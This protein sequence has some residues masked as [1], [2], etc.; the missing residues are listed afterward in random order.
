[1]SFSAL[2]E[3]QSRQVLKDFFFFFKLHMGVLPVKTWMEDKG[4][5]AAWGVNCFLCI[6]AE[7]VEHVFLDCW[8]GFSFGMCYN[9]H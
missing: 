2:R 5:F 1:M 6:K 9:E 8:D 4:M 3:C 7:T